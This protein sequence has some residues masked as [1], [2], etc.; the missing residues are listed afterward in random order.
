M[1]QCICHH[2]LPWRDGERPEALKVERELT[3]ATAAGL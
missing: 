3:A 2:A 1:H